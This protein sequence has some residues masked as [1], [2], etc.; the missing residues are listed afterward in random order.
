[1]IQFNT[2]ISEY[3]HQQVHFYSTL[4]LEDHKDK[5]S[6]LSPAYN[7]I[8]VRLKEGISLWRTIAKLKQLFSED[9]E[10]KVADKTRIKIPVCYEGEFAPDL[11]RVVSHTG[12]STEQIIHKHTTGKYLI[13]FLGFSPGFPYVG[14]MDPN[15][16]TPRLESPRTIVPAGSVAIGG[17]QTG[18]YP[19]QSPGGWN[20]IGRTPLALFKWN[21]AKTPALPMGATIEFKSITKEEFHDNQESL[22]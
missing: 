3:I 4:L 16:E 5:I 13:Y 20:I 7:S 2:E 12:L 14:G 21:Q 8:L 18:I 11:A 9:Y 17:K 15:L 19:I 22:F 10:I 1:M 6:N